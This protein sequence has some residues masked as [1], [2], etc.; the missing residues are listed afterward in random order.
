MITRIE[1]WNYGC[2]RSIRQDLGPFHALVGPNAIGNTTFLGTAASP[3]GLCRPVHGP[4]PPRL[5]PAVD[6]GSP[7]TPAGGLAA[8]SPGFW[9]PVH[10]PWPPPCRPAVN[11]GSPGTRPVGVEPR[12]R[13]FSRWGRE[14][15]GARGAE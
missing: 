9:R 12:C 10:G 2:L 6:G 4:L 8:S 14:P 1:A 7:T 11:G 15:G 13:G 3:P 5:R